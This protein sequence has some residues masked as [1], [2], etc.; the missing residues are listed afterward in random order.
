MSVVSAN[1]EK[2]TIEIDW[3]FVIC[4]SLS[5]ADG[6]PGKDPDFAC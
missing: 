4:A 3:H 6:L 1:F 2:K 5:G